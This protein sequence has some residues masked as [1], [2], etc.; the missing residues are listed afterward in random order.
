LGSG[1][2]HALEDAEDG[3][4]RGFGAGEHVVGGINGVR[5]VGLNGHVEAP[6]QFRELI[7]ELAH[8]QWSLS[9]Q[10]KSH[11]LLLEA[12][13]LPPQRVVIVAVATS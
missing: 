1:S 9:L 6:R 8:T 2:A 11:V 3:A 5:G 12:V 10:A 13:H 4:P 7:G